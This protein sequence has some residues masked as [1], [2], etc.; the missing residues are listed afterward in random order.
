MCGIERI[1]A[2]PLLAGGKWGIVA[3]SKSIVAVAVT[4]SR[5]ARSGH[6]VRLE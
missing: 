3:L 2:L 6:Y 1:G 4:S 5:K